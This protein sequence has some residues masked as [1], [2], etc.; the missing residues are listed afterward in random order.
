MIIASDKG[1]I[2]YKERKRKAMKKLIKAMAA[3]CVISLV[4]MT[5][6]A[7]NSASS[8]KNSSSSHLV[9]G[10]GSG[11]STGS[12]V[13]TGSVSTVIGSN[14]AV[15]SVLDSSSDGNGI[16]AGLVAG[17]GVGAATGDAKRAGLPAGAVAMLNSIDNGSL[18]G[19]TPVSGSVANKAVLAR[20]VAVTN[21]AGKQVQLVMAKSKIPASGVVEV[22]FYNNT[23]N[24]TTVLSA[25]V[26]K[27]T[28]IVT[29]TA[30]ADGTAA[31]IG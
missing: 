15:Y 28:G 4:P 10:S 23:N 3:A 21:A 5:A 20:T 26:D 13:K 24:T 11:T 14:G 18:A 19:I 27:T 9:G 6:F 1:D 16:T 7:A 29:F 12:S 22:L 31:I 30:P 8:V 17:N 2:K 25:A